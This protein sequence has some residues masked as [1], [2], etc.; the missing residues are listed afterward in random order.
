M[1]E[2]EVYIVPSGE[3]PSGG[4]EQATAPIAL[5]AAN[6]LFNVTGQRIRRF[7]LAKSGMK[8]V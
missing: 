5:A 7:P 3:P 8:L 6:A 4:G 1:P 2:I